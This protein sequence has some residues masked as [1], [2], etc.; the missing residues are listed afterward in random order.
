MVTRSLSSLVGSWE[1][2]Q[3]YTE[4]I[5]ANLRSGLSG[6]VDWNLF[7]SMEGGP[8]WVNNNVDSAILIDVEKGAFY[9]QPMYY[10][11]AHFSKFLPRGSV[12]H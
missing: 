3:N 9:K 10:A 7:L 12:S 11:M 8:S 1:R 5:I 4:H 6:W 2:G